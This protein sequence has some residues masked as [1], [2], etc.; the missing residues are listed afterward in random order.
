MLTLSRHLGALTTVWVVSLTDWK[1]TPQSGLRPS[2][3]TTVLEFDK[4]SKDFSSGFPNQCS[5]PPTTSSQVMLRHVS[6]G[7][8][9]FRARL[10][11]HP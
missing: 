5:T 4:R 3:A 6:E 8:S 2:T 11:F 9:Y 1:L 10:D 7:T